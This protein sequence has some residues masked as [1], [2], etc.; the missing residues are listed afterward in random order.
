MKN[1]ATEMFL[2]EGRVEG[3]MAY[4][5]CF[6]Y[7]RML[8]ILLRKGVKDGSKVRAVASLQTCEQLANDTISRTGLLQIRVQLAVHS[9]DRLL[10]ARTVGVVRQ[11]ESCCTW[12]GESS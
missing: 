2:L 1:L 11:V 7:I 4:Q 8:A 3:E 6:G 10:V 12:E 5:L 9:C